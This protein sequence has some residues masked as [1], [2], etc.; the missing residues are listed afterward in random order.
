MPRLYGE[1]FPLGIGVGFRDAMARYG[2]LI[3]G[4]DTV[5]IH[6]FGY[7]C[8]RQVSDPD[9]FG[10]RIEA[11]GRAFETKL[12][13]HD[14]ERWDNEA[15]PA[16]VRVH[17]ELGAVA[18]EELDAEDLV[19]YLDRCMA[20]FQ[21]MVQQHHV[22]NSC[23]LVPLGDFLVHAREWTG[24]DESELLA[25]MEGHST[26]SRGGSPEQ[27]RLV[28][29]I[30]GDAAARALLL[31]GTGDGAAVADLQA[32][33]GEVGAAAEAYVRHVGNHL[34]GGLDIGS[35]TASEVPEV[36]ERCLRMAVIEDDDSAPS[37]ARVAARE[38]A[39]RAS[40]PR[41]QQDQFDELLAEAR[42]TYRVRDERG[43]YSDI[44]AGGVLRRAVL[45]A[46][47]RLVAE[48]RLGAPEHLM[49]TSPAELL[50]AA[51]GS[52]PSADELAKRHALR[53]SLAT[54]TPPPFLGPEPT[55]PPGPEGLPPPLFRAMSAMGTIMAG[56]FGT[57]VADSDDRI[58]RG[59]A[60][61]PGEYEGRA[62]V[63]GDRLGLLDVEEGDVL[64]MVSTTESINPLVPLIGAIV[65]DSGGVVSHAAIVARESGIPAVVGCN[66]ATARIPDG[67]R[68][69]VNGSTGEV[70]VLV[71]A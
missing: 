49:E 53:E 12:W 58:V 24:A 68:V 3:E 70:E 42:T 28:A 31:N 59:L 10:R 64:V 60:A 34:V 2:L 5:S 44:W 43:V 57:P 17:L 18:P 33:P 16:A 46:G 47:R 23:A 41:D 27:G 69:R 37:A 6:G 21:A 56:V 11:A 51:A 15:K 4:I 40:V 35:P 30:R 62:R 54:F 29:A 50:A 39:L 71:L 19:A 32:M 7:N 67:A 38:S 9:E 8:V 66:D 20:H 26:V 36:L 52:G 13:R 22:F 14:V 48:G 55:P 45:A 63:L 25:L 1:L 61:S 65:T